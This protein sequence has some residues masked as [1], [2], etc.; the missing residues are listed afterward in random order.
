[1]QHAILKY[2]FIKAL[3]LCIFETTSPPL[4]F[5]HGSCF[6]I[7]ICIFPYQK[8]WFLLV[9]V[10]ILQ[11]EDAMVRPL[12]QQNIQRLYPPNYGQWTLKGW[13]HDV[14]M[15]SAWCHVMSHYIWSLFCSKKLI[16][17]CTLSFMADKKAELKKLNRSILIC[18]LE[19]LDIL[20][21]DPAS[22]AVSENNIP[23]NAH[24]YTYSSH[25]NL[26]RH[27]QDTWKCC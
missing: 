23:T 21:S 6:A 25:W 17:S 3:C 9:D 1:M 7:Y 2:N 5:Q 10:C 14:S 4:V 18:F 26:Y 8:W 16:S 27:S 20:I 22:P 19:L 24:Q 12:E 11:T 13:S 15:M